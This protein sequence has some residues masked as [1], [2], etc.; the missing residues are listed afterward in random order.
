MKTTEVKIKTKMNKTFRMTL[1][2]ITSSIFLTIIGLIDFWRT[3]MSYSRVD[4]FVF[5]TYLIVSTIFLVMGVIMA[6]HS[7]SVYKLPEGHDIFNVKGN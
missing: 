3:V 2:M 4:V 6:V 7:R 1:A 5:T